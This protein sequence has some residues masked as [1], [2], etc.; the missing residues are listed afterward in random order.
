MIVI[1]PIAITDS[2]L[3]SSTVAEPSSGETAWNSATSYVVGIGFSYKRK[4]K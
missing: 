1:P 2:N 3:V 4:K